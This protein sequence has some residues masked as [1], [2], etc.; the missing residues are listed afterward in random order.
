MTESDNV[1]IYHKTNVPGVRS[2]P[3]EWA[4]DIPR[5]D[6]P[7]EAEEISLDG[8]VGRV[9]RDGDRLRIAVEAG[10]S[11]DPSAVPE[12]YVVVYETTRIVSIDGHVYEP[13]QRDR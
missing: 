3:M 8:C 1:R 10:D 13:Q 2:A 12:G 9:W 5:D 4:M 6:V 7:A 11:E